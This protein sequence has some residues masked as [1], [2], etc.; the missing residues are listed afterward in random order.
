MGFVAE[1]GIL[2]VWYDYPQ[3]AILIDQIQKHLA[4]G[5]SPWGCGRGLNPAI[6]AHNAHGC[7]YPG[8]AAVYD[9][10]VLGPDGG[11]HRERPAGGYCAYAAGAADDAVAYHVGKE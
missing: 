2:A 10:H 6:P 11:C 5:E 8:H 4:D 9:E 3:P 7:G 1:L